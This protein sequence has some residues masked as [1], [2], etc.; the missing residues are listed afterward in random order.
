MYEV[1]AGVGVA[2]GAVGEEA[3]RAVRPPQKVP[4]MWPSG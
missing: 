2:E 1:G 4:M 3:A